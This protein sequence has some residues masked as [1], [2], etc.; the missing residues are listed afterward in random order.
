MI[1]RQRWH[2]G[3]E[4][5]CWCRSCK[6]CGCDPWVGKIPWN[7]KW[8]PTPVFLPEKIPWTEEPGGLQFKGSQRDRHNL[9]TQR[10]QQNM[11]GNKWLPITL[12]SG[13]FLPVWNKLILEEM[14]CLQLNRQWSV[15]SHT[16]QIT[17]AIRLRISYI[18]NVHYSLPIPISD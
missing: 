8:Q 18:L 3:K 7:R 1:R 6:R 4:S 2:S 9:A 5:T 15:F 17:I 12:F 16:R 11:I 10:Q 14:V 13:F